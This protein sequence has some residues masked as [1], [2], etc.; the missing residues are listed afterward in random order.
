LR[1]R[2]PSPDDT[3]AAARRLAEAVDERGLVVA[4]IGPL[5]AGKTVFAKGVA[6]GLGVDAASVVS[7]TFVIA[8]EYRGRGGRHFAHVDLYRVESRE[9]LEAAG[10]ADLFAPG[11]VVVVEW[12]DRFPDA[13]PADRLEIEISRPDS[14]GSPA[15]RELHALSSGTVSAAV[16]ERWRTGLAESRETSD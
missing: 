10:L 2:S 3:F 4:L 8:S 9:E 13:L 7:P 14:G 16:L 12:A 15:G 1:F 5:G 11:S 6:A